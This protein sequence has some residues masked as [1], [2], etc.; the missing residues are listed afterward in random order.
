MEDA[1]AI[2]WIAIVIGQLFLGG[3]LQNV[4]KRNMSRR[5]VTFPNAKVSIIFNYFL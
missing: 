5:P 3:E 2:F 1:G 4:K